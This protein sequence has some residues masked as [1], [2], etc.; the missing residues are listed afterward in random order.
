MLVLCKHYRYIIFL[1]KEMSATFRH[2]N[3][4]YKK[5]MFFPIQIK[6]SFLIRSF[7]IFYYSFFFVRFFPRFFL[8]LRAIHN[9][10]LIYRIA[11]FKAVSR[12]YLHYGNILYHKD[13]EWVFSVWR[14]FMCGSYQKYFIIAFK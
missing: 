8:C 11:R 1:R 9:Q 12:S 5:A 10:N 6:I 14:K 3:C 13:G 7:R 2:I 4:I